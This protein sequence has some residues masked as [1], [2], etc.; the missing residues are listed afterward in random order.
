[1]VADL[2]RLG[3]D[4][5]HL[6]GALQVELV[7][8]ELQPL[9]VRLHLLL[10]DAE[11]HVVR[12]RVFL[13]GVVKVVRGH[14]RDAELAPEVELLAEDA[15]LVADAVVLHLDVVA[16]APKMSRYSAAVSRARSAGPFSSCTETSLDR[17]PDRHDDALRVL[18]HQLLVHA[19]TVVEALEVGRRDQLQQVAVAGLVPGEQGEVVVLLLALARV[20]VEA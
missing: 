17:Q 11:Q 15:A 13:Q 3:E 8:V 12:L 19:R 16:S 14:D 2:G 1:M 4:V 10:L 9:Q 7:G 18:G 20:A 6:L 5:A